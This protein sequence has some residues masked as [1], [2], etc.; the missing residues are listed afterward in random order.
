MLGELNKN[1][2]REPGEPGLA[3]IRVSNG[4]EVTRTD[5][6]GRYELA[7]EAS[8]ATVFVINPR[9]SLSPLNKHNFPQFHY[10]Y[11]TQGAPPGLKYKGVAPTGP[12]PPSVD[13]PL[14]KRPEPDEFKIVM[15]GDLQPASEYPLRVQKRDREA[16]TVHLRSR[17][18]RAASRYSMRAAC[19]LFLPILSVCSTGHAEPANRTVEKEPALSPLSPEESMKR[20]TLPPGFRL[21]LVLSEPVIRQ[22]V[23]LTWDGSGR[24]YVVEMRGYMQDI[25]GN[26]ARNPVGR[27]SLHEDTDGDGKPDKHTVYMDQLVEPRAVLAVDDGLLI[28]EPPDLWYCR[29]LDGNGVADSKV[30]VYD[31]FSMRTSNVEHK[32]NGLLWGID[33]WIQ[34]SQH[35]RRYQLIK[36]KLRS[37][38][39]MVAGQWGLTQNDHGRLLFTTNPIPAIGLFVPP[40]YHHPDPDRQIRRGPMAA[41]V[42]GMRNYFSVWPGMVTPDLQAGPGMARPDDG[43]LKVFTA[44]CGQTFFRGD[45]LGSDI[46]GDYFVCEPVGRLIRRSKVRYAESGHIDLTNTQENDRGEFI[47]SSDGNFR[48]VNLYTGP[49]GCLYLVDMYHGVIQEKS[50]I[51]D[52]LRGQILKAGYDK[53]IGRGRIY[54]VVREGVKRGPRPGLLEAGSTELVRTL[55]HPNGWWRDTAQSLLVTRQV[56]SAAPALQE[57]ARSHAEPLARLH[58]LWTLDGLG[59]LDRATSFAGL[60]DKDARVRAAAIRT[61]ESRLRAEASPAH[62]LHLERLVNDPSTQVVAQLI[63]TASQADTDESRDLIARCI[64]K[65]PMNEWIL[66]AVAAA[67]P[68]HRLVELLPGILSHPR[69]RGAEPAGK[70]GAQLERW[71]DYCVAGTITGRSPQAVEKLLELIAAME[72][73]RAQTM[74]Q[75]IATSVPRKERPPNARP[76][77]FSSKPGGITSLEQRPEAPVRER[78]DAISFLFTWPGLSSF[79][80]PDAKALALNREELALFQ[81]GKAIYRE[82]C[83][84]CHAPDGNGLKGPGGGPLLAPPLPGS[85]RLEENR[86]AAIQI[87]LHGMTGELDGKNYEGLMAPFGASNDDAW[88]A[89][90]LT[91]VRR[92]WGNSGSPVRPAHVAELRQKFRARKQ[93]WTQQELNW[94]LP[95]QRK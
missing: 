11:K 87:M 28:G 13:F 33:N 81:K 42:R 67:A 32:A 70:E 83:V 21:E 45:R 26:G 59:E 65:H 6:T 22:P 77:R 12:L 76:L 48:P 61:L 93:P 39:V 35:G 54:R 89:A 4:F 80:E 31:R 24:L 40:H 60:R 1:G 14:H 56:R 58:A 63:L 18:C 88:V 69:F 29:D 73:P 66:N 68:R 57:M 17:P 43:T 91:Y 46:A 71:L 20:I 41:A 38:T 94:K 50:Y 51:N 52:Y 85:P 19:L 72:A 75:R 49:D 79:Q 36:R 23:A 2:A 55:A 16:G 27:I 95:P 74:L 78:L 5:V 90:V 53:N 86:E 34:T 92:E 84:T 8:D 30:R 3:K 62:Y 37:E 10:V 47:S 15:F 7:I 82:L 9:R 64:A 44:A 25:D